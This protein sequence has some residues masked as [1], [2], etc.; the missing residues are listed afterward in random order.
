[1]TVEAFKE[2]MLCNEPAFDYNGE[3]Y[4]ICWPNGKY[5]VTASD[6]PDDVKLVFKS[7]DDLLDHWIIQGKKLRDILPEIHFD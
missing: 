7:V 6:N 5:Y 4:S 2:I 3:E 1:M